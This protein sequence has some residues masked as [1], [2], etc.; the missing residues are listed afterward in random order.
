MNDETVTVI[1][2]VQKTPHVAIKV[3]TEVK[4]TYFAERR[5]GVEIPVA[6]RGERDQAV[7]DRVVVVFEVE[8]RVLLF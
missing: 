2:D 6:D 7:P 1:S 8:A 3:A 4:C 5:P